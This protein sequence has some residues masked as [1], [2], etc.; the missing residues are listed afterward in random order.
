[1]KKILL[2]ISFLIFSYS[3]SQK[4]NGKVIYSKEF[5]KSAPK[6]TLHEKVNQIKNAVYEMIVKSAKSLEYELK[7]NNNTSSFEIINSLESESL[8]AKISGGAGFYYTDQYNCLRKVDRFGETFIIK[9]KAD[10]IKWTLINENKKIGKYLCYKAITKYKK[11][12]NSTYYYEIVAW[13]TSELPVKFGPIGFSNLPGLILELTF[14]NKA[15]YKMK[16]VDFTINNIEIKKPVN[17][18]VVTAEEYTKIVKENVDKRL[19]R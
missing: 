5:N 15:T 4:L 17:G 18:K 16:K 7:I 3:F 11:S 9:Y 8:A 1:M 12:E 13:Y 6:D 2:I 14:N 19:N 10:R